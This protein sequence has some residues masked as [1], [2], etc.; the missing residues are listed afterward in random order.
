ML[1][2]RMFKIKKDEDGWVV[3]PIHPAVSVKLPYSLQAAIHGD[4]DYQDDE[5]YDHAEYEILISFVP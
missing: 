2:H 3:T 1:K 5:I 4:G